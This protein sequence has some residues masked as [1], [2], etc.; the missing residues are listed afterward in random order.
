MRTLIV[1]IATSACLFFSGQTFAQE[2]TVQELETTLR[3]AAGPRRVE[4][5][6]DLANAHIQSGD[7][8]KALG[9]AEDAT[10][11][12]DRIKR[13]DLRA[14]SLHREGKILAMRGKKG[15]FAKDPA[16]RFRDSN[17]ALEKAGNPNRSL[18][19][20][21]LELL[22]DLAIRNNRKSELAEIEAQIARAKSAG[23]TPPALE[24]LVLEKQQ[25]IADKMTAMNN[26][27]LE[28]S[29]SQQG[30]QTSASSISTSERERQKLMEELSASRA[31]IDRMTD[32]QLKASLLLMQQRTK[33]DS[34]EYQNKVDSLNIANAELAI[35]E[36]K[37][38]RNFYIAGLLIVLLLAGGTTYSFIR[39]RQNA[40]VLEEKNKMIRSEQERSENLL[41]NILPALVADEL[42]K[43]GSTNARYFEDVS[44][45]FA[46]FVGFSKIAEKLTPQQL[47]SELDTCFRAFDEIIAKY[48]LEKIKTIGD[49]YM[50]AGGLPNGGGSQLRDMVEA[51]RDMQIWLA[52]WNIDRARNKQPLFEA[53]I[54]IHSGPVVAGVV[55]SKKF[56]FDI[57]G[58]TVNIAARIE[59]A[60]EGGKINISGEVHNVIKDFFDCQYRGKIA[61]KNKGEI[62]MYFVSN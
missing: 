4:V 31:L 46:D 27:I 22:R 51:A 7:Y 11:L 12:A 3:S 36:S 23:D 35:R 50:A 49:A 32:D 42:K 5:L 59:A 55:G 8:D 6:L 10:S 47:V 58:D 13:N 30:T 38:E 60:G 52:T 44:V 33:L 43:Q 39:A 29:K 16:S 15:L 54:G 18:M 48:D 2:T 1:A 9:Y 25:E 41:L 17:K 62:D 28:L 24:L 20:E 61:A 37:S 14:I 57:W 56:A 34:M 19:L 21:N 53:R 40:K 45:L 26:Q